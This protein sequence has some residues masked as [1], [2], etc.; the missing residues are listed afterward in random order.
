MEIFQLGKKAHSKAV[1]MGTL[2]L[3]PTKP[4]IVTI[5]HNGVFVTGVVNNSELHL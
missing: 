5:D 2:G 1:V 4:I 3:K